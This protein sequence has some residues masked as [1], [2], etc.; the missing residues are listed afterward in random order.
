MGPLVV[1]STSFQGPE[2]ACLTDLWD[3][4]SAS[5]ARNRRHLAGRLLMT[6]SKKAF[7]RTSGPGHLERTVLS[8]LQMQ[9]VPARTLA[10]LLTTLCPQSLARMHAYPWYRALDRVTLPYD[11]PDKAVAAAALKR[12]LERHR[13]GLGPV[14]VACLDVRHYNDLVTSVRNKASVL[15]T[16]A[17]SLIQE[18]I[19]RDS[20]ARRLIVVDRQGGRVHYRDPLRRMF[21]HMDLTILEENE[22]CSRYRLVSQGRDLELVFKVKAD[23]DHLPVSLASMVSKYV[24]E[25]LV[26]CINRHFRGYCP[27]LTPTAGYWQDGQR[28]LQDLKSKC[29]QVKYDENCLVRCR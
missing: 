3:L 16:V 2:D 17:C 26:D 6:D 21:P 7:H 19:E 9:Q 18:A 10:E 20:D 4:L 13:L 8:L 1:S 25:L 15:F 12:D 29:P 5:V 27:D 11:D 14:R 22:H 24:R 23:R 28:F